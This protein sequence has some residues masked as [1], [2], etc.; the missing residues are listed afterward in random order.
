M[1][2]RGSPSAMPEPP[3]RSGASAQASPIAEQVVVRDRVDDDEPFAAR[4]GAVERL[5][6][7]RPAVAHHGPRHEPDRLLR[8]A[9]EPAPQM[10][11]SV[12]GLR[13]WFSS[14]DSLRSRSPTKRWP[15]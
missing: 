11:G 8:L 14:P 13:G 15:W 6:E 3:V 12:I 10:S 7:R 9:G 1:K 4:G 2:L 5:A